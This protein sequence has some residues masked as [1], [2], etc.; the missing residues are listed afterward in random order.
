MNMKKLLSLAVSIMMCMAANAQVMQIYKD[1]VLV[2]EYSV[3]EADR[4]VLKD[5][6]PSSQHEAVDLGLSV[7]WATCNVGAENCYDYGGR[8]AWGESVFKI[9]YAWSG[10]KYCEGNSTT[11]TKYCES[12][13][14]GDFGTVDNKST[15]ELEDDVAHVK[16]GENWRMPTDSEMTELREK[17]TWT[18]TTQSGVNGYNVTGSNGKS[19]FLPAA[20]YC[21]DL[22]LVN[23]GSSGYYWS[24]SLQ[25]ARSYNAW[26]LQFNSSEVS[27]F[28][29]NRCA[30]LSV[31]P[32]CSARGKIMQIYNG[33]TLV[34]EYSASEA[35]KVIFKEETTNTPSV[36]HEYVD[37][38]LSVKWAT[39]N[40]GAE[41]CYD[42]GD[43][44]AWGETETKDS[45]W[46]DTYKYCCGSHSSM[47]KYC[48]NKSRGNVDNKKTLNPE[49]D[50]AHVKWGEDWRMPTE[51]EFAELIEKCTWTWTIQNGVNGYMVTSANGNSI[52]MPANWRW[53]DGTFSG[54]Y[55]S[56]SLYTSDSAYACELYFLSS[57][58]IVDTRYRCLDRS[59]R[60]VCP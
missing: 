33:E 35:D 26:G 27:R 54:Y 3:S 9:E 43:Y 10:Y 31:R 44:Y 37:L 11:M 42:Y 1:D 34:A 36:N 58:H 15:L 55:W 21:Y 49:D 14:M 12:S 47:I 32:V 51:S 46:W 24:S 2:K 6:S 45:Y 20:G 60:P 30:G 38:G 18:W 28:V 4:V 8:Y 23:A 16:W 5:E 19:I 22:S 29:D 53:D 7:M 59:V 50:V 56:S 48:T 25:S 41:H 17:C 13:L 57:Q 39:C 40:V 52:F